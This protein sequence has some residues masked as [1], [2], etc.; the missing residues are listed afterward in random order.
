MV[1]RLT[2][3]LPPVGRRHSFNQTDG[4]RVRHLL[5]WRRRFAAAVLLP[6]AHALAADPTHVPSAH[7]KSPGVVAP[8]VLSPE[9][10]EVI[11]AQGAMRLENPVSPAKYY[12]YNDDK[13]N[14]VPIPPLFN[15]EAHKT[16]PDKN[17]YLRL[18]GQRGADPK[19]ASGHAFLVQAHESRVDGQRYIT[20]IHLA[21]GGGHSGARM[22]SR[23]LTATCRPRL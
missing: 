9:L 7:P 12:G 8:T 3:R 18:S 10:T 11:R 20:R 23:H 2:P 14:H 22:P 5:L 1:T 15:S 4:G 19:Y 16:E 6:P 13:P 17:T 21:A